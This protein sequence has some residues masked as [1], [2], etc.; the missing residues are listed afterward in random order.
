MDDSSL[1]AILQPWNHL[2]VSEYGPQRR[3][4]D[5]ELAERELEL[6]WLDEWEKQGG[7]MAEREQE[8]SSLYEQALKSTEETTEVK[9]SI[10]AEQKRT[11]KEKKMGNLEKLIL[12]SEQ[13][14][15]KANREANRRAKEGKKSYDELLL[16]VIGIL[17]ALKHEGNV[18]GW[19]RSGGLV[20]VVGDHRKRISET[21]ETE[22]TTATT[23][24]VTTT[25][26]T[27]ISPLTPRSKRDSPTTPIQGPS[28]RRRLTNDAESEPSSTYGERLDPDFE[29]LATSLSM[30]VPSS[31]SHPSPPRS[32]SSSSSSPLLLAQVE[33]A[34]TGV[35]LSTTAEEA[36]AA[37]S[38]TTT[39]TTTTSGN[40]KSVSTRRPATAPPPFPQLVESPPRG[41]WCEIPCVLSHWAQRGRKALAELGIEVIHGVVSPDQNGSQNGNCDIFE[42]WMKEKKLG[43]F[44]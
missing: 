4:L 11:K 32:S 8:C 36:A 7:L 39:P 23:S 28:K 17:D 31:P 22:S 44:R 1:K 19:M 12:A 21:L 42:K 20:R 26:T 2:W 18:A 5:V 35:P 9:K 33:Q 15:I 38:T 3:K 25:L 43:G 40:K 41:L 6:R 10:E 14:E 24:T 37:S 16:A 34:F 29:M 30:S 27:S 13:Q